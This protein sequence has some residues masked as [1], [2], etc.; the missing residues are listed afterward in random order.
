MQE[1]QNIIEKIE[2]M[3]LSAILFSP[4]KFDEI[5][6]VLTYTDF[7]FPLHSCM[8]HACEILY[9]TNMPITPEIVCIE[10]NKTMQISLDDIAHIS[11]E[12]PTAN[13]DT[14]VEQI[15]NASINR[16]LLS[17]ASFIR[18]ESIKSGSIAKDT[19]APLIGEAIDPEVYKKISRFVESYDGIEGT[20]DSRPQYCYNGF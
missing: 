16:S 19:L 6:E 5:C 9:K 7:L 17:L 2:R 1:I 14:Y 18:D 8:F 10:M 3:V 4:D 20:H 13:L 12:F 15:K 11:A